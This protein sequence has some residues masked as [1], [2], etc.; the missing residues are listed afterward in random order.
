MFGVDHWIKQLGNHFWV[1][2]ARKDYF[3]SLAAKLKGK[4]SFFYP[5]SRY[6]DF[7]RLLADQQHLCIFITIQITASLATTKNY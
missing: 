7:V 6:S 1:P 3:L 4:V 2:P 5:C